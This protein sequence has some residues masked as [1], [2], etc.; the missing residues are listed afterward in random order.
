M[1]AGEEKQAGVTAAEQEYLANLGEAA[2][3]SN[4]IGATVYTSE[5]EDAETIGEINDLVVADDGTIDAAVIGV[6]GFLGVGEKNVAISFDSIRWTDKDGEQIAVL[7]TTKEDLEAAPE[8]V[9]DETAMAPAEE[10]LVEEPAEGADE[11]AAAPAEEPA[12]GTDEMAAAPTEEPTDEGAGEMAAAPA[13]EP[14]EGADVAE[15][16][17]EEPATGGEDVAEAPA[18]EPAEGTDIAEAPAEEPAAGTDIAQAPVEE[19]LTPTEPGMAP[20]DQATGPVLTDVTSGTLSAEQLIGATVYAQGDENVGDVG[21]VRLM[22]DGSG[23]DAIIID[24][25]GFL[26]M[27]EKPVALAFEALTF[28]TDESGSIYVYT[29]F[30]R[31]ELDA[32]PEYDEATYE[33]ERETMRLSMRE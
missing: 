2:L 1:A 29:Q 13:E 21:D 26:G 31:D 15:A 10:P 8:F 33:A 6:G 23:I 4:V 25:G 9:P 3:A 7:E 27:G 32:A 24:V 16:P 12:E 30:T 20:A 14:A 11:M 28:K 18:E 5:A 17:A 19:P 22:A